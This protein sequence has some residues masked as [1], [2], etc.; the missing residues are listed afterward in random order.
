MKKVFTFIFAIAILGSIQAQTVDEIID[1]YFEIIGGKEKWE[2]LKTMRTEAKMSM[3]GMEFDGSIF[4]KYPNKQRV[5]V[6][7]N[8]TTIV[9]AY[10]GTTAWW[11]NPFA[12]GTE[13][14][15]MPG[16]MAEGMTKQE[17]ESPL[18]NYKDKRAYRRTDR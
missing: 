10:D 8:G 12:G 4:A 14:Q 18:L 16:D 3:Q 7:V 11:I 5:N 15:E 1:N 13:A 2:N 17:F 9:Q 6:N